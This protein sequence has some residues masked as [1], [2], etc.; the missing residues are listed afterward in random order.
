VVIGEFLFFTSTLTRDTHVS[1]IEYNE[2]LRYS[3]VVRLG[4]QTS[5][6]TRNL[7]PACWSNVS[8]ILTR[9]NF[10]ITFFLP[11]PMDF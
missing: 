4:L 10:T 3:G 6:S 8:S 5:Y 11:F 2:R 9:N 7:F 1:K